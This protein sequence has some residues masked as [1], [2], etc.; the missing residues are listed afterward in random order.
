MGG[1]HSLTHSFTRLLATRQQRQYASS[2]AVTISFLAIYASRLL[3][4]P[5]SVRLR[6]R[7]V[8]LA[9]PPLSPQPSSSLPVRV[10]I[11]VV[12]IV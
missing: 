7:S 5:R 6:H 9:N 10:V 4:P 1:R 8:V 11:N 12:V 3:E 2:L